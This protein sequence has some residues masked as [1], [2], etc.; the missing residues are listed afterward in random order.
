MQVEL[1]GEFYARCRHDG[2]SE[3]IDLSLVGPVEAGEWLLVFAGA[4]RERLEP[5][6]AADIR[7]ALA[8]LEAA[9]NGSFDPAV[10][11]AGLGLDEPQLPP[12]LAALRAAEND[13]H[14]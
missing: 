8:A 3:E 13:S 6:A 4:A 10:H 7:S 1:A 12:H 5:G 2:A 14:S 9:M 11:L